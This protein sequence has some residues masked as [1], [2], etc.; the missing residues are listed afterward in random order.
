MRACDA[1]IQVLLESD[2]PAV[3]YGDAWL[4]HQI[5]ARLGWEHEG[6]ATTRRVL[7]ALSKTPGRLTKN[8]RAV[9]LLL[10]HAKIESTVR[11][12]GSPRF[13]CNK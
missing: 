3:M 1:A 11:Y 2:N 10:G 13:Q 7:R 6:P 5:A 12:L 8:L 4:C 9:Q